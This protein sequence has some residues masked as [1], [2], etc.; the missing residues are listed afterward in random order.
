MRNKLRRKYEKDKIK[1]RRI[2]CDEVT[3]IE[4]DNRIK[5]R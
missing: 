2:F 3:G 5:L 1:T 4:L